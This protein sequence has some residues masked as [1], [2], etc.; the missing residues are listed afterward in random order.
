MKANLRVPSLDDRLPTATQFRPSV[1]TR[2][3]HLRPPARLPFPSSLSRFL[4]TRLSSP[5]ASLATIFPHSL[6]HLP[7]DSFPFTPQ[8]ICCI[9]PQQPSFLLSPPRSS[10]SR[11]KPMVR[12][13]FLFCFNIGVARISQHYTDLF[14]TLLIDERHGC[15][16]L[17]SRGVSTVTRVLIVVRTRLRNAIF[18]GYMRTISTDALPSSQ[19]RPEPSLA[20]SAVRPSTPTARAE[21][22]CVVECRHLSTSG[23]LTEGC[24]PCLLRATPSTALSHPCRLLASRGRT[25]RSATVRGSRLRTVGE[26]RAD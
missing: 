5:S 24:L 21:S 15:L 2:I 10:L 16:P 22:M 11:L 3:H 9:L 7:I 17:D 18:I 13:R 4:S 20:K 6:T 1:F 23:I 14:L 8:S 12:P 25:R 26:S 19:L